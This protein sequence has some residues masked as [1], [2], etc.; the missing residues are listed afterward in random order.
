[1]VKTVA[2]LFSLL[3]PLLVSGA[4]Q[5]KTQSRQAKTPQKLEIPKEAK[6]V[7]PFTWRYTDPQGKTWIYRET[8]FGVVRFPEEQAVT[9]KPVDDLDSWT[10]VEEGDSVRFERPG[11]FGKYRWTRK[12][13]ELSETERQVWE[14][15]SRKM[16]SD[17]K[18][19]ESR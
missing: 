9:A 3:A 11:P 10:A 18:T 7:E 2:L 4:E 12:K 15:E 14:R 1:M 19:R 13:A 6:K 16:S 5:K 17:S 8:P